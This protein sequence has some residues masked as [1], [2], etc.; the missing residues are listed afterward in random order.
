MSRQPANY[1][2]SRRPDSAG[3]GKR[4]EPLFRVLGALEGELAREGIWRKN[5]GAKTSQLKAGQK[6]FAVSTERGATGQRREGAEPKNGGGKS[7]T[8]QLADH[9]SNLGTDSPLGYIPLYGRTGPEPPKID[10][11]GRR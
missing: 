10:P 9:S 7:E 4:G 5:S 6:G 1:S 8:R 2:E 11:L 3:D